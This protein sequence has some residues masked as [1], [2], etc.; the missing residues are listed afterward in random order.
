MVALTE[1]P[2]TLDIRQL[3]AR[4]RI[5]NGSDRARE[6]VRLVDIVQET[7][8]P[9]ALYRESYIDARDDDSVTIEGI[10]FNS[11]A[12]SKNVES[13][14]RVFPNIVTCGIELDAIEIEQGDLQ[15]KSWLSMLKGS[16]LM[17]AMQ[18]LQEYIL[19][20]YKIKKLAY[21]NPGSGDATVWPIEQQKDLFS[22]F[23]NVEGAIGVKLTR[24]FIMVPDMSVC[25]ILIPS[26][27]DFQSCQ[28]C[29][30]GKCQLRRAP[31]DK[32]LWDSINN[33]EIS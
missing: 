14:E 10:H 7:G 21:M 2:F 33:T 5:Q 15:K 3:S 30:R 25:G 16:L 27:V 19:K 11:R 28:L 20:K 9:K 12:L 4:M 17:I 8:K 13:V 18:Y 32:K 22:L 24:S 23:D 1:I 6:F 29:H 31:F 26:E